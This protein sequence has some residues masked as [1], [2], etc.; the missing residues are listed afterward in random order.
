M[1]EISD[2]ELTTLRNAMSLLQ[3]MNNDPK[4]R[5]HL[6]KAIKVVKPEVV[7]E[8]EQ[9]E[10]M[11]KPFVEKFESATKTLEERI[12][13]LDARDA[14]AAER[15]QERALDDSFSRL[16]KA[17]YTDD[18]LEKIKKLM[19]DRSI[20]DPEAAAALFDKQNPAPPADAPGFTP[21]HWNFQT[22][23]SKRDIKGLFA[24]PEK[25]A[26]KEAANVLNEIRLGN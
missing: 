21:D 12:A 2:N 8:E 11:A 9:A 20:P 10:R 23:E 16:R 1:A 26:D 14:A 18:G 22:D 13:A 3:G 4:S 6:E 7:T 24:D 25:W 17:G 19:V 15:D 5:A